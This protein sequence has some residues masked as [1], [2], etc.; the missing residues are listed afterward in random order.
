M[1]NATPT[2]E[3]AP[4][5]PPARPPLHPA[6]VQG[7]TIV[8]YPTYV[9][10]Y[11]SA[12]QFLYALT[13]TGIGIVFGLVV[14]ATWLG[15]LVRRLNNAAALLRKE[16]SGEVRAGLL[17]GSGAASD[18]AQGQAAAAACKK[19]R[20]NSVNHSAGTSCAEEGDSEEY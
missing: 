9:V 3:D 8:E 6:S 18:A 12:R 4:A 19:K 5:W 7:C 14:V 2:T 10:P 15:V 17:N 13:L 11:E 20:N 16:S 1:N